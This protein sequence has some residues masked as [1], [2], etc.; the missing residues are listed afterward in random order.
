MEIFI[1]IPKI[2]EI[3]AKMIA[4]HELNMGTHVDVWEMKQIMQELEEMSKETQK[5]LEKIDLLDK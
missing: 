2:M 3:L 4:I 5:T 1:M